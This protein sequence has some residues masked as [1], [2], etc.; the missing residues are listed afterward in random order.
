MKKVIFGI[1]AH[2]DDEAFG[3]SGTLLMEKAQGSEIH[4]ICATAGQSGMNPDQVANLGEVRLG[5]WK[6][7]GALIG[8]DSMHHLGFVDG[9][10]SNN[11][12]L[13]IADK[14]DDIVTA[15]T[16]GRTDISIEFMSIDHNGITGHLDHIA[17]GR[18]A[19]YV[20]CNLKD[21][22]PR[23]TRMRLACI[24]RNEVPEA[25]CQWLY[26]D[27]G[28]TPE[29][30]QETV[31]ASEYLETIKQIMHAHKTQREDCEAHVRHMGDRVAVNNFLVL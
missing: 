9:E 6:T 20:Y 25:N 13:S 3:P 2:P 8:A 31:D 23:V 21:S 11:S 26:M 5:E 28:R 10:L 17:I 7:A 4:L 19:C 16:S 29:E 18:I 30:I 15:V 12:Y 1:F 24:T 27:A 22:D 14:I